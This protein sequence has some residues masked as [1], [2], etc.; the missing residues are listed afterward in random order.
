MK[1][2]RKLVQAGCIA[3]AVSTPAF[4]SNPWIES[5]L[6]ATYGYVIGQG[7]VAGRTLAAAVPE[8]AG[9]PKVQAQRKTGAQASPAARA[10][11]GS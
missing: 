2:L 5:H 3:A 4:A 11:R 6:S 8:K 1:I 10:A 7:Q 9:D